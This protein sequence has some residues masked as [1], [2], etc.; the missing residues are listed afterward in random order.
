M[1]KFCPSCGT[2]NKTD[3]KFCPSC[4]ASLEKAKEEVK[5]EKVET[6]STYETEQKT[7]GMAIAGF[8]VSCTGLLCCGGILGIIGAIL[9]GVALGKTGPG[10]EGG[11]G[12]AIAGLVIGIIETILAIVAILLYIF[13]FAAEISTYY[14]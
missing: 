1:K 10:K 5:A 6:V 9:S 13:V 12:L 3:S 14:Y 8:V 11:R 2:E 4:G 7:N